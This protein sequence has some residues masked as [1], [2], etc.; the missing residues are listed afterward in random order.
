MDLNAK[1]YNFM[2]LLKHLEI[3]L[4]KELKYF[5]HKNKNYLLNKYPK[6]H[7]INLLSLKFKYK[8]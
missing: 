6:L 4:L 8:I 3:Y 1:N 5:K 7:I 2:L